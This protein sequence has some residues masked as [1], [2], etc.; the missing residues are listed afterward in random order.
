MNFDYFLCDT[1][2]RDTGRIESKQKE[3]D[4]CRRTNSGRIK[5]GVANFTVHSLF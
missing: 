1:V 5:L 3:F 2:E 4:A